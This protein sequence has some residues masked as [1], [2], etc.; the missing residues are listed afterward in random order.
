MDDSLYWL[1]LLFLD[2]KCSN[3]GTVIRDVTVSFHCFDTN[4]TYDL[5]KFKL[6]T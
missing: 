1:D 4:V 3:N 5:M 2:V 6:S